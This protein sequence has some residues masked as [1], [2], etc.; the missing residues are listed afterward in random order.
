MPDTIVDV[1]VVL[2]VYNEEQSII[3]ELDIIRNTMTRSKFSYEIIVVDDASYD[4]TP[5]ILKDVKGIRLIT[6][7]RNKGSGGSRKSGSYAS[8]GRI[9]VWSDADLTYPNHL[10]PELVEQLENSSFRQVIGNR[11]KEKGSLRF[12]RAPAKYFLRQLASFLTKTEIPDLNSG[13]RAFYREDGLKIMFMV[14]NGFSCVS[15][16]T[17]SFLCNGLDVGYMQIEYKSRVGKSKFHPVKDSYNYFLQ[18]IRMITYFEPLRIFVPAALI[19]FAF[20]FLKNIIDLVV[21]KN[22]QETDIIGYFMAFII[23]AVGLLADLIV[24]Q[25]KRFIFSVPENKQTETK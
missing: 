25:N 15:T 14:P 24:T 16:M 19:I 21:T 11:L 18:I 9:I 22:T 1:S 8:R 17:L 12:L 10:I 13:F 23:F 3:K 6:H 20:T 5:S 2:A 7:N 4:N